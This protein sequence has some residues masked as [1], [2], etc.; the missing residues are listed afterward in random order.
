MKSAL[1]FCAALALSAA[2]VGPAT[3][4]RIGTGTVDPVGPT[5]YVPGEWHARVRYLDPHRVGSMYYTY[6][7]LDITA[8]TQT[9]CEQQLAS[10]LAGG[11]ASV[12]DY[13]HF[14]PTT[15]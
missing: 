8:E 6:S 2:A 3:A 9:Y 15:Y 4:A 10:I 13:C 1:L 5:P 14:V 12:I 11:N 7:Y